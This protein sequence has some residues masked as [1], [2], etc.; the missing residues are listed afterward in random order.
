[1]F[2]K[3]TDT[4]LIS[5]VTLSFLLPLIEKSLWLGSGYIVLSESI[6]LKLQT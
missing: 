5:V 3:L 1:M 2:M 4:K 6:S